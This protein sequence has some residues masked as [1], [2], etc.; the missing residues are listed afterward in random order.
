[1]GFIQ[2]AGDLE[3]IHFGTRYLDWALTGARKISP[4]IAMFRGSTAIT[5]FRYKKP[6]ICFVRLYC[7]L[8]YSWGCLD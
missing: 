1:M 7:T 6:C 2:P 5:E 3:C 4:A 8:H